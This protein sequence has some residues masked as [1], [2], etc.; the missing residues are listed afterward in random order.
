MSDALTRAEHYRDLARRHLRLAASTENPNHYLRIAVQYN[1]LTES[2]E[3][4]TSHGDGDQHFGRFDL[5]DGVL[6]LPTSEESCVF[7]SPRP[8]A[9]MVL[10]PSY[11]RPRR[12]G[13]PR[14]AESPRLAHR[15]HY[16][17]S[18]SSA[19][20]SV[21]AR[22][23]F[24]RSAIAVN[25]ASVSGVTLKLSCAL[26]PVRWRRCGGHITRR[27]AARREAVRFRHLCA[28]AEA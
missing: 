20:S 2:E 4:S 11:P 28:P 17:V 6:A 22:S 1:A 21:S 3:L 18:A 27:H 15:A 14:H 13:P 16:P 19:C 5:M 8:L 25:C 12:T 9:P 7:A 10:S 26:R 23:H 24:S